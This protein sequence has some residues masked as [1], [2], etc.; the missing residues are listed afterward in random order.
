MAIRGGNLQ[1]ERNLSGYRLRPENCKE[2]KGSGRKVTKVTKVT[3]NFL[4]IPF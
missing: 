1:S 2:I 3:G 4:R